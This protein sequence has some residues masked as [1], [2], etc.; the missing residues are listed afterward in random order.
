MTD[1]VGSGSARI[2][3]LATA[4]VGIAAANGTISRRSWNPRLGRWYRT[5]ASASRWAGVWAISI[6]YIV[7]LLVGELTIAI[8]PAGVTVEQPCG[9][10]QEPRVTVG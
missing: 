7:V 4:L 8:S 9:N 3:A 2:T 5:R 6:G 1:E 10:K